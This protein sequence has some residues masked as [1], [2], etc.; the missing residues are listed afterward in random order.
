MLTDI[1]FSVIYVE[2]CQRLGVAIVG[3]PVGEDFLIWP[4]SGNS[5]VCYFFYV[6][7]YLKAT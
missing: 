4:Q 6:L 7:I 2:V 1:M 5:A 3:S